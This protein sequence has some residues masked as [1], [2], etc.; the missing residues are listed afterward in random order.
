MPKLG[1]GSLRSKKDGAAPA[2][3]PKN[4][5]PSPPAP[6]VPPSDTS[7][8]SPV[9]PS[10]APLN[11][12]QP[13][14]T[15]CL[16]PV[17]PGSPQIGFGQSGVGQRSGLPTRYCGNDGRCSRQAGQ[18]PEQEFATIHDV[19]RLVSKPPAEDCARRAGTQMDFS[20]PYGGA[21]RRNRC[22]RGVL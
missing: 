1:E 4:P 15:D 21:T 19:P 12:P 17:R 22:G 13:P 18:E 16:S 3:P 11:T 2:L 7:Q 8:R 20:R 5:P 9:P 10:S 14:C 6:P